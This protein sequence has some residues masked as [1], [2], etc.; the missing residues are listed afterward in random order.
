VSLQALEEKHLACAKHTAPTCITLVV[1]LCEREFKLAPICE[2]CDR[3]ELLGELISDFLKVSP[4]ISISLCCRYG[5]LTV[6]TITG[7][8]LIFLL[9]VEVDFVEEVRDWCIKRPCRCQ[10]ERLATYS[11]N[12]G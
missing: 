11:W 1:R 12:L 7:E 6:L 2:P 3:P 5:L 9:G 4:H 10:R 8:D